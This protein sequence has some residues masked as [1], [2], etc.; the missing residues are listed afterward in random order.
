MN[1][2]GT[3][4]SKSVNPKNILGGILGGFE[5]DFESE[6]SMVSSAAKG[7]FEAVID[8]GKGVAGTE[9]GGVFDAKS[10]QFPSK[11]SIEF[12]KAVQQEV[13]AEQKKKAEIDRKK[14]FFTTLK[15]EQQKVQIEK[16]KVFEEEINDIITNLPT[17]QKNRMLHYQASYKDKSVYQRAEL[18]KKII[19]EQRKTEEQ[20]KTASIPSPAK[21]ASALNAA[22]EGG[23][24]TQGGGT[25]NLSAQAVG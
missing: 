9:T 20:E 8:I 3:T 18:R 15:E 10:G 12:N 1:T 23:S 5:E 24:G 13:A 19:E 17:E 14:I 6:R 4:K 22:M 21:Q 16:D 2:F 25:A 11:G 7:F